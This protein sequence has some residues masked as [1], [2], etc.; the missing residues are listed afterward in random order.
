M[1]RTGRLGGLGLIC[2]GLC[3]VISASAAETAR[4]AA[5]N[6][7]STGSIYVRVHDAASGA[8]IQFVGVYSSEQR[9]GVL[10]EKSGEGLITKLLPGRVVLNTRAY[11]YL[12]SQDT[13]TIR[14]GG[15][16]TLTIRLS[17]NAD[18]RGEII[19][20]LEPRKPARRP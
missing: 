4:T 2:A 17:K 1:R 9:R 6:A 5:T 16:D 20:Y 13:V 15:C 10:V 7:G 14:V 3:I 11:G 19:D 8:P 18:H 12:A